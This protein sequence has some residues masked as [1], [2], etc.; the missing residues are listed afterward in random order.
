LIHHTSRNL[1]SGI[2]SN[3]ALWNTFWHPHYPYQPLYSLINGLFARLAGGDLVGS[4]FFNSLLGLISA[5]SIYGLGRRSFGMRAALFAS[6]MFLVYEQSIIHF[7]MSYA[8]NAAGLGLLIMTLFLLRRARPHNDLRAGFGLGI[9]AASHPLFVHGAIAAFLCRLT[10]PGSWIRLY[11]PSA[12]LVLVTLMTMYSIMG[13]WLL[14]DLAHLKFAYTA[15]GDQDGGGIRG[16]VNFL[17]FI[18]QDWFHAVMAVGLLLCIPI[19]KYAAPLVGLLVLFLLVRN[20]QN[21]VPF[22]YQAIVILPVLCLGWAGLWRY[23]ETRTRKHAPKVRNALAG[24]WLIPLI[25]GCTNFIPVITGTLTPRNQHWVTQS[26]SEVE[27][28]A[29]WLNARTTTGDVVGGNPN[30]AWLLTAETVPYLQMITWYGLPTQGYENG[31]KRERFRFDASL[32]NCK[33]A[34]LGDIDQRWAIHEPNV[35]QLVQIMEKEKW[36]VV[37]QG[38]HYL[39]LENPRFKDGK[40]PSSATDSP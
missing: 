31:N 36:S 3:F 8:H 30:I 14:E 12:I 28:A 15:R 22:Y 37:W 18:G 5:L 11:L 39:I 38:K 25:L 2:A 23:L 26:T 21:L 27:E 35:M 4:R 20:R 34:I 10:K 16:G 7:R 19:R 13:N 33:F 9:C 6:L 17:V 24:F 1:A 32:E 40:A 29:R